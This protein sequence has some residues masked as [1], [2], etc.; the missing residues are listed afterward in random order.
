MSY[1]IVIC[2]VCSREL[3]QGG[4]REIANGWRHCEGNTPKCEGASAEYA[5]NEFSTK[6]VGRGP[7][8]STGDY[9]NNLDRSFMDDPMKDLECVIRPRPSSLS[10]A[11]ETLS[12]NKP[13]K[14]NKYRL[15]ECGSR[16]LYFQ[17]CGKK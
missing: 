15:C 6:G 9:L 12:P 8:A 13:K 3:H 7:Y 16:Q 1:G 10:F 17:C 5:V 11:R 4:N 14:G 2:S